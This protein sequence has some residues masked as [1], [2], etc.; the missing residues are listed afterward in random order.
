M[1]SSYIRSG[2]LLVMAIFSIGSVNQA[3][4]I[5][6]KSHEIKA[7]YIYRIANFI[8]WDNE[9]NFNSLKFCIQDNREIENA[10]QVIAKKHSIRTLPVKVSSIIDETCHVAFINGVSNVSK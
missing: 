3:N 10:L 7:V 4:A 5:S 6:Y 2:L 8:R 9:K 1:N